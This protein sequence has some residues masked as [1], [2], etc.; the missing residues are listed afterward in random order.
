[1]AIG[2]TCSSAIPHFEQSP[3]WSDTTSGWHGQVNCPGCAAEGAA[4]ALGECPPQQDFVT[5]LTGSGAGFAPPQH[6]G[7]AG[8]SGSGWLQHFMLMAI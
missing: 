8:S 1:M 3:G 5:G 7:F 2:V 4:A 6:A